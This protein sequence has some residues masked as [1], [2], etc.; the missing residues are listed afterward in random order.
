MSELRGAA[1]DRADLA[2]SSRDRDTAHGSRQRCRTRLHARHARWA[3][4]AKSGCG[5][6]VTALSIMRLLPKHREHTFQAQSCSRARQLGH[7]CPR[8]RDA[9]LR[10]NRLA[11][12]FQEP[13]TSLNPELHGR[14]PDRRGRW[15]GTAGCRPAGARAQPSSCSSGSASR[16]RSDRLDEY[17]HQLS[18][19][20]RQRVMI[21]MALACKPALLIADEPTTALD[22]TIQRRSSI[23]SAKLRQSSNGHHPHHA[24]PRRGG[25][26]RRRCG[27]DVRRRDRRARRAA[28]LFAAPQHPL[29]GRPAWFRSRYISGSAAAPGDHLRQACRALPAG[30]V[31]CR[32]SSRC[33]FADARCRSE[34]PRAGRWHPGHRSR[35]WKAPLE[36]LVA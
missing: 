15:Y 32:F 36:A 28:R 8:A 16:R 33:P 5:K 29:H 18:G 22:V 24:R 30:F 27:R 20:M 1:P 14:R 35:C 26:A 3:S 4:S 2:S 31:G 13:M 10:G 11:M 23:C 34:A 9:D 19:G 12:I 21:A 7:A 25:R 6:S 17:P